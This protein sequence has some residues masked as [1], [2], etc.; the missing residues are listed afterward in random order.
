M[1]E[2]IFKENSIKKNLNIIFLCGVKYRF[3]KQDK[4]NVLKEFISNLDDRNH[5]VIL[6][7]NFIFGKSNKKFLAYDDIFMNDLNSV[8]TLTAM[9]SDMVFIIHESNSTAAELGMFATNNVLKGKLCL[10]VPDEFSVEENKISTFLR[11]AFFRKRND[12]EKIVFYPSTEVWR[13]SSNK[14]DIRTEFVNNT[15]GTN[16]SRNIENFMNNQVL[17]EPSVKFMKATYNR[18]SNNVD[19]MSYTYNTAKRSINVKVSVEVL[20]WQIISLFNIDYFKAGIRENK[21]ISEHVTF[22]S[23]FYKNILKNTLEDKEGYSIEK[24]NVFINGTTIDIRKAIAYLLYLFQGIKK[25]VFIQEGEDPSIRKIRI[26]NDFVK[27]CEM[28]NGF[29]SVKSESKFGGMG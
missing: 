1:K 10:L 12:I 7:E 13:S 5:V 18:Y 22:V 24:V 14:S 25:I 20:K 21:T 28:Y 16:L 11:L 19:V 15:I 8:E 2:Y 23:N 17:I 29:I 9:F 6:E 4:R 3:A 27:L 26:D